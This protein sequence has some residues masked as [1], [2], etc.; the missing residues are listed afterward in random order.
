M[1]DDKEPGDV[2]MFHKVVVVGEGL[3]DAVVMSGLA[4]VP[5]AGERKR[6]R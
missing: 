5:D 6:K 4:A 2:Y 3:S 1:Q